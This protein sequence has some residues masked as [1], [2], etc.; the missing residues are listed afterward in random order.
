MK[1]TSPEEKKAKAHARYLARRDQILVYEKAR[2]PAR[3]AAVKDD[4]VYLAT[5]KANWAKYYARHRDELNRKKAARVRFGLT[6]AEYLARVEDQHGAC[7]ICNVVPPPW[8]H[9][10]RLSID[11]DHAT[12]NVR[13]LLCPSCNIGIGHL[14]DSPAILRKAALYLERHQAGEARSA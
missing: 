9:K 14:R 1:R 2:Y 7:A 3:Y 8:P 11:H 12:G 4:P 10:L 13:D 5:R 6:H